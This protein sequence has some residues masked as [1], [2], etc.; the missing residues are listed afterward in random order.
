MEKITKNFSME[1]FVRSETA[2]RM[3]ISNEPDSRARLAIINLCTKL[4]QPL[5][6]AYG[7][8]MEI[9]SGYRC[10]ALNEAVNG[11]KGSQHMKGEAADVRCDRPA[12][13]VRCLMDEAL[14]F[15][16]CIRYSTFVHLSYKLEGENRRQFLKGKY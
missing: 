14:D 15:D 16:Q 12:E 11:A 3:G 4:L 2:G 7:K 6:D 8:P 1:E 9:N 13:L 10:P 5:R